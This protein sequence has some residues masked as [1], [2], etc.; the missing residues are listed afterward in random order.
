MG[1]PIQLNCFIAEER[2]EKTIS[3]VSVVLPSKRNHKLM[4]DFFYSLSIFIT[5]ME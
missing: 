5:R 1:A 2:V 3:F 4:G